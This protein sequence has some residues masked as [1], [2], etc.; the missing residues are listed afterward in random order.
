MD[1][2]ERAE[3]QWSLLRRGD[4]LE[5]GVHGRQVRR[6]VLKGLVHEL[7]PGVFALGHRAITRRAE[8]LAAVWWCGG[9]AA[10]ADVSACAYYRWLEEDPD[11]PPPVHVV[12]TRDKRSRPGVVVHVTRSLLHDDVLTYERLLRVTD[13]ARTLIDRADHLPYRELRALADKPRAFPTAALE[14]K[15]ARLRGWA[16][17][18]TTRRLIESVDAR[19]KSELERRFTVYADHHDLPLPDGRNVLVAGCRVDCVY[20]GPRIAL[21]LDS[22]AHH[23]RPSQ[24]LADKAR[25]R[26]Y[27]RAGYTPIRV[28]WAELELDDPAVAEELAE[29]LA[30]GGSVRR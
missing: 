26:A 27:R 1:V 21:E 18:R 16:G 6:W 17:G 9:D 10:L 30:R 19:T 24:M 14:R 15:H 28:M 3:A 22:R 20:H 23:E 29:L 12:T 7:H 8:Y 11:H 25:D 4:L 5:L 13:H 2:V